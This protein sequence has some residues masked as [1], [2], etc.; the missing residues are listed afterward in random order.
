MSS[1]MLTTSFSLPADIRRS[2]SAKATADGVSLAAA[3]R[4]LLAGYAAGRIAIV[5]APASDAVTVERVEEIP[6]PSRTRKLADRAF[7]AVRS[8]GR[9]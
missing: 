6:M 1:T 7:A 3:V 5:A 4:L 2:A 8:H 9:R